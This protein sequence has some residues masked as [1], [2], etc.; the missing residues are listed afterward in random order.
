MAEIVEDDKRAARD[1]VMKTLGRLRRNHAVLP[2]PDDEGWQFE[3]SYAVGASSGPALS[4][5]IYERTA[6]AL[7][8][9]KIAILIDE[10]RRNLRLVG[11]GVSKSLGHK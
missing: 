2:A 11:L 6:I 1:I 5:P 8:T 3:L 9:E 7:A 10:L 4:G